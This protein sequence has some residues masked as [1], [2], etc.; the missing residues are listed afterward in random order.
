MGIVPQFCYIPTMKKKFQINLLSCALIKG[1]EMGWVFVT[2]EGE[3]KC[4]QNFGGIT[5]RTHLEDLST[6]G[7]IT[8]QWIL[9]KQEGMVWT[10]L[11][12]LRTGTEADCVNRVINFCVP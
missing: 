6:D 11:T 2:Y 9:K 3:G 1:N 4:V 5:E 10:G 8:L 12:Y 7:T